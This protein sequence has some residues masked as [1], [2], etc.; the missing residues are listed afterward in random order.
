MREV[1]VVR[2]AR[3]LLPLERTGLH[4]EL[5][6]DLFAWIRLLPLRLHVTDQALRQRRQRCVRGL[7]GAGMTV[8]ARHLPVP[9][10]K[11]V[12]ERDRLLLHRA[13]TAARREHEAEQQD[14][15]HLAPRKLW[16]PTHDVA[17]GSW[18][19]RSV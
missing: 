5:A 2:V 18:F 8:D 17:A 13:I 7:L 6:D 14:T 3:D 19:L 12:I 10:V 4:G 1:D 9:S 11:L 15:R 16:Q